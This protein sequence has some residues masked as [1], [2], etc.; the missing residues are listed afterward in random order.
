MMNIKSYIEKN[1]KPNLRKRKC[2]RFNSIDIKI[3]NNKD[4][5]LVNSLAYIVL[6]IVKFSSK[7]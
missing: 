6:L 1:I 2:C 4:N 3:N 7:K 5:F